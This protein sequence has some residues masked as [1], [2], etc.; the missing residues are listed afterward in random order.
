M[1]F[2]CTYIN[3]DSYDVTR[4]YPLMGPLP[5]GGGGGL[6]IDW[7]AV[8]AARMYSAIPGSGFP[9]VDS[10]KLAA[11]LEGPDCTH[12]VCPCI[13]GLTWARLGGLRVRQVQV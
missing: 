8:I 1:N 2:I 7:N 10:A 5:Y 11:H 4:Q 9:L 3:S 13:A 6:V 12:M